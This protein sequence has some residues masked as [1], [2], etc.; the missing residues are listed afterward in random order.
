MKKV[1]PENQTDELGRAKWE[2]LKRNRKEL[3]KVREFWKEDQEW[4]EKRREEEQ[5]ALKKYPEMREA[6]KKLNH[7]PMPEW[8]EVAKES[9]QRPAAF[10]AGLTLYM[11]WFETAR[12]K[13]IIL[14]NADEKQKLWRERLSNDAKKI[15]SDITAQYPVLDE[16]GL[17]T[18]DLTR[19]KKTIMAEVSKIVDEELKL[20][21][22]NTGSEWVQD[23]NGK[24]S[25]H[26][27]DNATRLKWLSITDELLEVWDL[28]QRAGKQ[29]ALKSFA[30]IARKLRR[31]TSTVRQQWLLA[32]EKIY[33]TPYTPDVHFT[34]EQAR[35]EADELC[36]NCPYNFKCYRKEKAGDLL[37]F[38]CQEYLEIAGKERKLRAIEFK[39]E[40]FYEDQDD[41]YEIKISSV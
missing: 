2:F 7:S 31:P 26:F 8:D 6:F 28:Y 22:L 5:K 23:E 12:E 30:Q 16:C 40:L 35:R 41:D 15:L 17:I 33:G 13:N 37:W 4:Y 36:A 11:A 1:K 20:Y 9:M 39:E 38:P 19:S 29:S 34:S 21:R 18:I 25:R 27:I 3:K 10:N 24:W 14:C 32:Y